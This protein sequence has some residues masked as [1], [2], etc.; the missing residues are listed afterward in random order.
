MIPGFVGSNIEGVLN[1]DHKWAMQPI[2]LQIANSAGF[3]DYTSG[4]VPDVAVEE[5]IV[6][7]KP[8][9]DPDEVMLNAVI[10]YIEGSSARKS[11]EVGSKG[12]D[13]Q[14]VADSRDFVPFS[15]EMY[16]R[17]PLIIKK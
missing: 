7:L 5:D 16:L 4:L 6:D 8:F 9:G 17:K 3:S 13:Y 14:V 10:S 15:R 1:P 12:I 11:L 2:I